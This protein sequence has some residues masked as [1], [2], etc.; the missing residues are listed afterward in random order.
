M[1]SLVLVNRQLV[2]RHRL[3]AEIKNLKIFLKILKFLERN[4]KFTGKKILAHIESNFSF[5]VSNNAERQQKTKNV[6]I[7]NDRN[8]YYGRNWSNMAHFCSFGSNL[9]DRGPIY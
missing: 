8:K 7:L 5:T 4:Q 3:E 9:V 1:S 6:T 2:Q